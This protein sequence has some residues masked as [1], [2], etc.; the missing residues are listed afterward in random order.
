MQQVYIQFRNAEQVKR[1]VNMIDTF[2]VHFDLGSG[3]KTVNAKSILGIL[4]LDLS[5][6]LRLRYDSD[7]A[8]I[9]ERIS[10]FLLEKQAV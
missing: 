3:R 8:R 5:E 6:P 9:I 2:E 4:A 10:P 7:D 1:F